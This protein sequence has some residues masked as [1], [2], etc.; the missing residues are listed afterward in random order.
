MGR[1]FMEKYIVLVLLSAPGFIAN[2]LTIMLG[3]NKEKRGEF[4]SVMVYFTYS[5]FSL[6]LTFALTY[7]FGMLRLDQSWTLFEGN[8]SS[9]SFSAI[10]LGLSLLSSLL[11]GALWQLLIKRFIMFLSNKLTMRLYG[12]EVFLD[13]TLFH[14]LFEDGNP[15]FVEVTRDGKALAVGVYNGSNSSD[16][17]KLEL[18][19]YAYPEYKKWLEYARTKDSKHPLNTVKQ[20]YCDITSGT[21]I[22]ELDFPHEWK[23]AYAGYPPE[24]TSPTEA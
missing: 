9:P 5:F 24:I 4:Q 8:F 13:G 6:A 22:T 18:S 7:R 10:F 14:K 12:N 20:V 17:D 11:V 19:I 21:I 1:M 2:Q 15:H 16:A 23:D 3:D